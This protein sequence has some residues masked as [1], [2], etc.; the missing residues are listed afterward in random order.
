[1]IEEWVDE[2]DEHPPNAADAQR[3]DVATHPTGS[4]AHRAG[5]DRSQGRAHDTAGH[6][7]DDRA[8]GKACAG[9]RVEERAHETTWLGLLH[10]SGVSDSRG[11]EGGTEP[12]V[13]V[14]DGHS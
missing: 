13:N 1:M 8:G 2:H 4:E 5:D 11:G 6:E 9:V 14:D 10:G 3:E 7:R 12:V